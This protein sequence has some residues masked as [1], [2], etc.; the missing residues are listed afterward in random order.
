MKTTYQKPMTTV[1]TL[2]LQQMIAVSGDPTAGFNTQ[3][4]PDLGSG[5]TS[6]N[7]SRRNTVWDDD[8]EEEEF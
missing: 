5:I 7:L 4:A 3:T 6:G 2:T 1:V 8:E